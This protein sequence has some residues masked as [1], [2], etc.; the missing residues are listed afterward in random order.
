MHKLFCSL[1]VLALAGCQTAPPQSVLGMKPR[2]VMSALG[3]PQVRMDCDFC[4]IDPRTHTAKEI[5]IYNA[6]HSSKIFGYR[7]RTVYFN[8]I[9]KAYRDEQRQHAVFTAPTI[10]AT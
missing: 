1:L 2:E 9:D 7:N 4:I 10:P 8:L 5:A 3:R 6:T